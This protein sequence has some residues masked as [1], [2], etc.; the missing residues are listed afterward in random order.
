LISGYLFFF[1]L[2]SFLLLGNWTNSLP[3]RGSLR[4]WYCLCSIHRPVP[5]FFCLWLVVF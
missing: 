1:I 4:S 2:C 3:G 5:L